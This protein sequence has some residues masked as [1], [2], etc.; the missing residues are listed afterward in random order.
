MKSGGAVATARPTAWVYLVKH[1]CTIRWQR[2][3]R[4]ACALR[5][6]KI[7]EWST[8]GMI[9]RIPVLPAGWTDLSEVRLIGERWLTKTITNKSA[10]AR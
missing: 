8:E 6:K 3:D 4:E 10:I 9:G 5:G 2:G 1:D 7:G